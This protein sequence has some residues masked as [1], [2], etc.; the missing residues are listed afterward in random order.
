MLPPSATDS[1]EAYGQGSAAASNVAS[2]PRSASSAVD[3]SKKTS[4]QQPDKMKPAAGPGHA[5]KQSDANK[6]LTGQDK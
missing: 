5:D 1:R 6:K 3:K 2:K 4:Y